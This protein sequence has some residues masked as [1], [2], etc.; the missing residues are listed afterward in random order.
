[1]RVGPKIALV[2]GVPILAAGAIALAGWLLLAQEE[3]ARGGA[4]LVADVYHDIATARLVRDQYAAADAPDRSAYAARFASLTA[5]AEAG[6]GRLRGFARID[7]QRARIA[8]AEEALAA[9]RGQMDAFVRRTQENDGLIREM[10]QRAET[11]IDLADRARLRQQASNADLARSL[12]EKVE[13][14]RVARGLVARLN[15]LQ[16]RTAESAVTAAQGS[17]RV[18]AKA[19]PR[20]QARAPIRPDPRPPNPK[21]SA[22]RP[23]SA[24]PAAPWWRRCR[25]TAV[26]P[27]PRPSTRWPPRPRGR[28]RTAASSTAGSSAS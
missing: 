26:R 28:A 13:A 1:M 3:R 6:L 11:L 4:V 14:L 25:P 16:V 23:A 15:T 7:A 21:S 12:A 9:Y 8:S 27:R 17:P 20:V 24:P 22:R 2:G 19:Q 18:Q 5:R 10:T